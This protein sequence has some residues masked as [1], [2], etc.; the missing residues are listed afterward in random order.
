MS[1]GSGA[2]R[3]I[4]TT[5]AAG[6]KRSLI[7][8]SSS[9]LA[10]GHPIRWV[11][12]RTSRGVRFR[13]LEAGG[14]Q[15]LPLG[16][17]QKGASIDLAQLAVQIFPARFFGLDQAV[18]AEV[19]SLS[20]FLRSDSSESSYKRALKS[21]A[22]A[23]A[24]FTLMTWIWPKTKEDP[25]E[26]IPPQFAKV[27]LSQPKKGIAV[28][29]G[30]SQAPGQ[31]SPSPKV[32]QAA[33]VQAF[34]AAA[35]KNAVSGLLKGGMTQLLAQ[36]DI[37][38]GTRNAHSSGGLFKARDSAL[39]ASAPLT[40]VAAL[41]GSSGGGSRAISGIGYQKGGKIGVEGQGNSL[42]NIRLAD[43]LAGAAIEEGLTKDEVGEVI[44]KHISEV[45]YCYESAMVRSPDVE[46]KLIVNFTIAHAGNV[47]TAEVKTST[48]PD[49][50]LDDCILRRL[51][52]W[53]FPQ[54]KGGVDVAITY[55]FIFKTLGR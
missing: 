15:E 22:I 28:A 12:E 49:A 13:D 14:C 6:C 7:W 2:P 8:E 45:R 24:A 46:G 53:N 4:V 47:K 19:G 3:Y 35:L 5:T 27:I 32:R 51:V 31:S 1:F 29:S 17:I 36:N 20:D 30:E 41:A 34:R 52:T 43:G 42:M 48:L 23:L 37:V 10:L 50:K 33:M 38:T 9:P 44:H 25:K 39:N 55:P 18:A 21:A 54:T 16:K 11:A 40:G 26:L